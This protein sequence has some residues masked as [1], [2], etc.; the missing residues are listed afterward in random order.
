[1]DFLLCKKINSYFLDPASR[2][3]FYPH[4][5]SLINPIFS[6]TIHLSFPRILPIFSYMTGDHSMTKVTSEWLKKKPTLY[7]LRSQFYKT[8]TN[9]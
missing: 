4:F 3:R 6:I 2:L 7:I 9:P 5:H 1:M 8:I